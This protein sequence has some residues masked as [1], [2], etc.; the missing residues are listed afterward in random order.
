METGESPNGRPTEG[1]AAG[2]ARAPGF[3]LVEMLV[4]LTILG[5]VAGMMV[6]QLHMGQR[7][8][9][10]EMR[11]LAST[12][13]S[14]QRRAVARQTNVVV[15]FDVNERYVRALVDEDGD[16]SADPGEHVRTTPLGEHVVFGR[17]SAPTHPLGS[18]PVTFSKTVD[19]MPSVVF[20]R[21]GAA[22][23]EGGVY[24]TTEMAVNQGD[25][26]EDTRL[27]WIT[28]A[29]GRVS[30]LRYDGDDGWTREF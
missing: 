17:G 23:A 21:N 7:Q 19:G 24:L 15:S 4:I 26:P 6:P 2:E 18:G 3:S 16:E 22:S 8:A 25:R 5:L 10:S 28:R 14:A 30:W 20:H 27:L 13:M 1:R 29:T 9:D 12:V 11:A